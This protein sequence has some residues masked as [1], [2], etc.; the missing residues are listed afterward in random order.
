MPRLAAAL[1]VVVGFVNV[2]SAATPDEGWRARIVHASVGHEIPTAAHALALQAGIGLIVVGFYL[3]RRHRRAWA[4]TLGILIAAG[5]L[6]LLKGFDVEEAAASWALAAGLYFTRGAFCVR[7]APGG[8]VRATFLV[9]GTSASVAVAI[10]AADLVGRPVT[11]HRGVAEA[12]LL[13]AAAWLV[14]R[15]LAA[16]RLPPGRTAR[17]VAR[18]LVEHHGGDTL[19]FFKLRSDQH[20]FFDTT[21]TAFV[22]YRV[23]AR[24]IVVAGDPVG[25]PE[26]LPGLLRELI[27][28]AAAR[29]LRV[30]VVGASEAFAELAGGAG[31]RGWYLGDEA[32]L[33]T[34][35][36]S[37][38]GR[39]I[40]KVRQAVARVERAGYEAVVTKLGDLG[41]EEL[42]SLEA[43]SERARQGEPERGYSMAL[44]SLR[45]DYLAESLVVIARGEDG[46]PG[47]F[48]H[49]VPCFGRDAMSLGFMRRDPATPN[50][51]MEFL[52]VRSIEELSARGVTELSLNFAPFA[53]MIHSPASPLERL[54]GRL[55]RVADKAF[56]IESLYRFNAKFFPRWQ[57]RYLL[58]QGPLGLPRA[59]L[60]TMWAERQLPRPPR[61]AP[62][63]TAV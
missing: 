59:G 36:F 52:I 4:V 51:V 2:L 28:F 29:D 43:L 5:A 46:T 45:G 49:V 25:P 17:R 54:I 42:S 24:V 3:A 12:A 55:A 44:D 1:A 57:P 37:L 32:I 11:G 35:G 53:R 61:R 23:E 62:E 40:R 63:P 47:G 38:E 10:A 14:F 6:N 21:L 18:G 39:R 48:L 30:C 34:R 58:Y 31:L 26:A 22:A 16:P 60:A 15:P 9:V 56:G 13:I 41:E 33:D 27:A 7:A 19:S 8:W 50:G 20:Y